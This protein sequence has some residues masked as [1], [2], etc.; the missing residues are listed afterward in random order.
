M[1]KNLALRCL[2][3]VAALTAAAA[4]VLFPALV[5]DAITAGFLLLAILPWLGPL[6]KSVEVSGFGKIEL[7]ELERK[8]EEAIGAALSAAQ[9][10]DVALAAGL[11]SPAE[12]RKPVLQQHAELDVLAEEYNNIRKHDR[13]GPA[14]SSAMSTVVQ[15]MMNASTELT[16][17]MIEQSLREKDGGK[18]LLAYAATYANPNSE[19]LN[20]LVEAVTNLEDTPFGQYW[21]IQA[22]G[23]VI[24]M[25]GRNHISESVVNALRDFLKRLK[26]GTDRY[27]ELSRILTG[28][29]PPCLVEQSAG[30]D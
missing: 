28:L 17:A 15:R 18:R 20:A 11:G 3:T 24:G 22:T 9:K 27:Y 16:P 4:H 29:Q 1:S 26:P 2:V 7:R 6:I 5:P 10:A 23:R 25:M 14:R 19:L 12:A 30:P 21:G 8:A 13:S